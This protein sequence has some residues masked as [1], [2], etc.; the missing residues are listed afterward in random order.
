MSVFRRELCRAGLVAADARAV[1][2][3][4][5]GALTASGCARPSLEAAVL[6]REA[7][8]PTGLPLVGRKAAIPHSDPVHVLAPAIAVAAL[9]R[10][11]RFREMGN[12][13]AE[14]EV[15]LVALLA[16]PSAELAQQELVG[17]IERLQD[18]C[19]VDRLCAAESAAALHALLVAGPA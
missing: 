3:E 2:V 10:P 13:E 12:P 17:L 19:F 14:L 15:E 11:V 5:A 7:E 4:L 9:A 18:P 8:S 1:I 16:L 6:S